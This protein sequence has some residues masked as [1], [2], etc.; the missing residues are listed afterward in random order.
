MLLIRLQ[1]PALRPL[2]TASSAQWLVVRGL[3]GSSTRCTAQKRLFDEL[4]PKPQST[5]KLP[6]SSSSSTEAA[7]DTSPSPRP[8][9]RWASQI[10]DELPPLAPSDELRKLSELPEPDDEDADFLDSAQRSSGSSHQNDSDD[11]AALRATTMLVLNAASK[12]LV[13]SDFTRIGAKGKHVPGWVSGIVKVFQGR[14]QATLEP[15][16]H[17]FILF[18]RHEAAV[19]Y[20]E[21]VHRLRDLSR[22][23]TPAATHG[24]RHAQRRH[25]PP[26]P[27]LP[28][29]IAGEDVAA[30][31]KSFTLVPPSHLPRL[32]ISRRLSR[33]RI[34]ELDRG[35]A[36]V[37]DIVRA[38]GGFRHLVMLHVADGGRIS[39]DMLRRAVRADGVERN[40]PW[41]VVSLKTGIIP[42]GKSLLEKPR[43][44]ASRPSPAAASGAK[45]GETDA[46][47]STDHVHSDDDATNN[48][49]SAS[50]QSSADAAT[51]SS[52]SIADKNNS[53]ERYYPRFLVAFADDAE[54][55]RFI[56][57]WH[58]R[59]LA[60]LLRSASAPPGPRGQ[61]SAPAPWEPPR[62]VNVSLLW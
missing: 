25:S 44:G 46:D 24:L 19:A 49:P 43:D 37:D 23:Y 53:N 35:G 27:G 45:G 41:R 52:S 7:P 62:V 8:A 17:Y 6:T 57:H 5:L 31:I 16:G 21:E 1:R 3:H 2:A 20:S 61:G 60:P 4:F 28:T 34:R 47:E 55:R 50:E 56:R 42:F 32:Q 39:V 12:Q 13:E 51:P 36:L 33:D 10:S 22:R 38:V 14:D 48:Q 15:L 26:P 30:L 58:R 54:A 18:D 9:K 11:N 29:D 59:E 40:L